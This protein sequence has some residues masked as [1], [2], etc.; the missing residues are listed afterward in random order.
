MDYIHSDL[1][2]HLRTMTQENGRYFL[3]I[4]DDYSRKCECTSQKV[5]M[6][7]LSS[8]KSRELSLKG[9]QGKT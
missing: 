6:R 7:H 4:I 9:R 3:S 1:L 5:R 2:G 8:S